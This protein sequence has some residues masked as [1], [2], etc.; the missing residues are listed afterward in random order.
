MADSYLDSR[1]LPDPVPA[2]KQQTA[3]DRAPQFSERLHDLQE[4]VTGER[5]V[6][7]LPTEEAAWNHYLNDV[8]DM[9]RE[10]EAKD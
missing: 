7:D 9:R 1:N 4:A 3:A 10:L 6:T 2:A 8:S 5:Y